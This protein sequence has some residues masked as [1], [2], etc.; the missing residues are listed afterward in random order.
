MCRLL[1]LLFPAFLF[2]SCAREWRGDGPPES[3]QE[4]VWVGTNIARHE[5]IEMCF[6][7]S[8]EVS[9]SRHE[10]G[11]SVES[12]DVRLLFMHQDSAAVMDTVLYEGEYTYSRVP[13]SV[14][15]DV[16]HGSVRMTLT[17]AVTGESANAKMSF[18]NMRFYLYFND[19]YY[20]SDPVRNQ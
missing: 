11:S 12:G 15:G 19:S 7:C 13:S 5:V 2:V 10:D 9:V 8:G 4:S 1:I 14:S 20:P 6:G 17:E 3:L 18:Y 16:Y